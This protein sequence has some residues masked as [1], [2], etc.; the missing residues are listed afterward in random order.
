MTFGTS[1]IYQCKDCDYKYTGYEH[2]QTL[3]MVE[4]HVFDKTHRRG[5]FSKVETNDDWTNSTVYTKD[6]VYDRE[7]RFTM[8]RVKA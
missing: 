8:K 2:E 5:I 1:Y 6:S 7:S 4:M 3:F